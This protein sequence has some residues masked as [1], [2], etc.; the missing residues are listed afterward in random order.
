MNNNINLGEYDTEDEAAYAYNV[1]MKILN[2]NCSDDELNHGMNLS[3]P[4]KRKVEE[5]V[6]LL[7]ILG[8]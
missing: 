7:L 4:Q 3:E 8:N 1:G 2:P 5:Q 6:K